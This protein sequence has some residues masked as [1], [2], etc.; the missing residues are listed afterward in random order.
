MT[1]Y[2]QLQIT[3]PTE[4][5][6]MSLAEILVTKKLVA[7]AQVIGPIKSVYYWQNSLEKNHEILLLAKTKKN[8]FDAIVD[9]IR[10]HHSYQC[11]QIVALPL[12]CGSNDYLHWVDDAVLQEFLARR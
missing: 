1:D 4:E 6:A 12:V 2:I 9:E 11:P 3:F 7:C 5:S 10:K 8:L